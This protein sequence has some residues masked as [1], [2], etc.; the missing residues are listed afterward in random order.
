MSYKVMN[1]VY[2]C[3][4]CERSVTPLSTC[5]DMDCDLFDPRYDD[6]ENVLTLP[7]L[8]VDCGSTV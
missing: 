8:E 4:R 6:E 7:V 5:G 3:P 2:V 1:E